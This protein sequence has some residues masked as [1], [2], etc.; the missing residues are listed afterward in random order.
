MPIAPRLIWPLKLR[1]APNPADL[2]EYDEDLR[3]PKQSEEELE[4]L[5]RERSFI[6][7]AQ[8]V[9]QSFEQSRM[10]FTGDDEATGSRAVITRATQR[11]YNIKP[12]WRIIEIIEKRGE[13]HPVEYKITEVRPTAQK[14][15]FGLYLLFF[16]DVEKA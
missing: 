8:L 3:E 15:T 16:E 5:A 7:K 14:G 13:V 6:V 12:H 2:I 4:A 11:R 10:K 1:I 9:H